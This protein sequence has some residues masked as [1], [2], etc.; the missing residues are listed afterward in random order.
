M[1]WGRCLLFSLVAAT[2]LTASG[3]GPAVS[4]NDLGEVVFQ[5]PK[6]AGADE[7]YVMAQLGP[8]VEYHDDGPFGRRLP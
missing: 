2:L 5:L 8:P 4:K 7:P 6:V 3:C 1:R